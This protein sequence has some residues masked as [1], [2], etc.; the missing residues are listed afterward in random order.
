MKITS[1]VRVLL[2]ACALGLTLAP[3]AAGQEDEAPPAVGAIGAL[4]RLFHA[5]ASLRDGAAWT[6]QD[7]QRA[8]G[9]YKL[10]LDHGD[11]TQQREARN[12]LGVIYMR[13]ERYPIALETLAPLDTETP[14]PDRNTYRYNVGRALERNGNPA[15]ALAYYSR[16][17]QDDA[18]FAAGVEGFLRV[19]QQ[20]GLNRNEAMKAC[21]AMLDSRRVTVAD[22]CFGAQLRRWPET[23]EG[24]LA[25]LGRRYS[26]AA[27]VPDIEAT[28][29]A[30][31]PARELFACLNLD[32]LRRAYP[33]WAAPLAELQAAVQGSPA[34]HVDERSVKAE[35]PTWTTQTNRGAFAGLL[36]DTGERF[37]TAA[38]RAGDASA[39][40]PAARAIGAY[41]AAWSLDRSRVDG[42]RYAAALLRQFPELKTLTMA[43]ASLIRPGVTAR[44]AAIRELARTVAAQGAASSA[45]L[46]DSEWKSWSY[47]YAITG[48][49]LWTVHAACGTDSSA[50]DPLY[51]WAR[52]LY[53]EERAERAGPDFDRFRRLLE[54]GAPAKPPVSA[55]VALDRRLADC[56][57]ASNPKLA[58]EFATA[59]TANV[60]KSRNA[61]S[62]WEDKLRYHVRSMY[63]PSGA[64]KSALQAGLLLALDT[65]AAWRHGMVGYGERLASSAA[66]RVLRQSMA[67]GIDTLLR[68][69]P[70]FVYAP[71]RGV[72]RRIGHAVAQTFVCRSDRLTTQFAVWRVAS[73]FA[74]EAASN[75]WRPRGKGIGDESLR[76]AAI[77]GSFVLAGDT[78]SNLLRE[79]LPRRGWIGKVLSRFL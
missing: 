25:Y 16:A 45:T 18:E 78:G 46:N 7:L 52:A 42:A 19:V 60:E 68:Q 31:P 10:V 30:V 3:T 64:M 2:M 75:A 1:S 49:A 67:L 12:T 77:R 27:T 11:P 58:S 66:T 24:V 13:L 44:E 26:D 39:Q 59:I 20:D 54:A 56:Y 61:R 65:P 21:T 51:F 74:S 73:A 37:R 38:A 8:K 41:S 29:C 48:E 36:F 22:R 6:E 23:P 55:R 40:D 34:V 53:S 70:H 17:V 47:L 4:A 32:S 71:Y 72:R 62:L 69:D 43:D 28:D 5:E 9:D 50:G 14:A 79:F 57:A 63:Y 76:S 35:F 15:E 33:A